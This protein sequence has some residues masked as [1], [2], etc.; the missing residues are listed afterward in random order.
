MPGGRDPG[1]SG[2]K[3]AWLG[4]WALGAEQEESGGSGTLAFRKLR[5]LPG[6]QSPHLQNGDNSESCFLRQEE[7]V[8]GAWHRGRTQPM[9]SMP[10]RGSW[11]P[12]RLPL[13]GRSPRGTSHGGDAAGAVGSPGEALHITHPVLTPAVGVFPAVLATASGCLS[14][15]L[16]PSHV[17]P[18]LPQCPRVGRTPTRN[19]HTHQGQ[20]PRDM[21]FHSPSPYCHSPS[22]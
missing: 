10:S 16:E 19:H 20:P 14:H 4:I 17:L 8:L 6:P 2:C 1:R 12:L 11:L 15:L 18:Q 9:F 5:S 3:P 21:A 13:A 7:T 22:L